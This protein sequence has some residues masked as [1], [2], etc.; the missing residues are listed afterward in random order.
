MKKILGSILLAISAMVATS[1]AVATE[2][3]VTPLLGYQ[4]ETHN[5]NNKQIDK[6]GEFQKNHATYGLQVTADVDKG[7]Q[8]GAEY[9]RTDSDI[10]SY[11]LGAV[12]NQ[13][14]VGP[15]YAVGGL[16]YF[17]LQGDVKNIESAYATLGAGAKYPITDV[18]AVKGEARAQYLLSKNEWIPTALLG[19]EFKTF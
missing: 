12:V 1:V 18:I 17:K 9:L 6:I 13:D 7:T 15:L 5:T 2:V 3:N 11:Q 8:V 16:G 19:V 10:N 4:F 14:I